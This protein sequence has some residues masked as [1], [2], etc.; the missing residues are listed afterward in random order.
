MNFS[1]LQAAI[2][3]PFKLFKDKTTGLAVRLWS[4]KLISM[5][6][7]DARIEIMILFSVL[8]ILD[9]IPPKETKYED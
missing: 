8:L 1:F 7:L 4:N 5:V 3:K 9:L 2:F 6:S